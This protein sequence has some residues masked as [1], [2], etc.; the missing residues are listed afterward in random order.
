VTVTVKVPVVA[1]PLAEKVSV[2]VV[3]VGLLL[4]EAFTPLGRPEA[5]RLTLLL[6][7]FWGLTVIVLAPLVPWTMLRLPGAA[8]RVKLGAG[9]TVRV[10]VS[11]A[12]PF[13]TEITTLVEPATAFV[14]TV[15][16]ADAAPAGTV[17][18]AGT[19]ATFVLLLN[20]F[21]VTPPVGAGPLRVTVPVDCA[22]P[23][24]AVGLNVKEESTGA[25]TAAGA[26]SKK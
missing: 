17:I 23:T 7:P 19:A 2:L 26:C 8:E 11:V 6:K 9:N 24:T 3:A 25:G 20:K 14:V 4:N 10:A 13:E 16:V 15:K 1:D 18:F 12:V 22:P 21:T 5:E